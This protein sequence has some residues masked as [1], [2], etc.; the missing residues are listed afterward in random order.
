M[1]GRTQ[2]GYAGGWPESH[3]IQFTVDGI[4]G[5]QGSKTPTGRM[6]RTRTG[7]LTPVMR[8]SSKKVKPWRDAVAAAAVVA[9]LQHPHRPWFPLDGPLVV[10]MTFTVPAPQ[11][12]KPTEAP[13]A[14]RTPDLSKLA[15]STEDALKGI[16]WVDDARVVGYDRLWKT[17]R[18]VDPF[19]LDAP[20][21]LIKVRR[22]TVADLG[23]RDDSPAAARYLDLI[24]TWEAVTAADRHAALLKDFLA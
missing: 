23:L 9:V 18:G 3:L 14:D 20:G 22:A 12:K 2:D 10:H 1:D 6:R 8:E 13:A 24:R 19:S 4:P 17:Y 11:R 5:P 21:A 15:R 7:G 16:V